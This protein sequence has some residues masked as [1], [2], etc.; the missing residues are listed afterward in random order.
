MAFNKN[1]M[2][3]VTDVTNCSASSG[4]AASTAKRR[5]WQEATR[6]SAFGD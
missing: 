1:E 4:R 2:E 6:E 5:G 3:V